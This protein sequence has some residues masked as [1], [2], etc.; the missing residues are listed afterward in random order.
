MD[1][2]ERYGDYNEVEESPEK[3]K[4][5]TAIKIIALV[6]IF[7][8]VGLIAVR[9]I[10]FNYYPKSMKTLYFNETLTE[11]YNEKDGEIGAKTQKLKAPYD[12][13]KEGNFLCDNLIYVPELGQL[14]ITLRYNNNLL[15]KL[16]EELSIP[17]ENLKSD[18]LLAF[19][20]NSVPFSESAQ[21]QLIEAPSDTVVK[22][23]GMYTYYKI[24]FDGINFDNLRDG[25]WVDLQIFVD[26]QKTEEPYG[27][28]LVLDT[29]ESYYS[30]KDY[31]L[32]GGEKP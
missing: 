26:G 5:L 32:S 11:Y 22:R 1:D 30:I 13:E 20:L 18:D 29:T 10:M 27:R 31:N 23:V 6:L 7:S 3:N 2:F 19:R 16:S 14:Q 15:N 4:A 17:E 25:G 9:L 12:D 28:I 8:V 21:N 24:V